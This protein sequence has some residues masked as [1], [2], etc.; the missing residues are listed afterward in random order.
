MLAF[1]AETRRAA[2]HRMAETP[3]DLL[4]IGGGITG[5]GIALDAASRGLSV[6]LVEKDDFASGTSGRSSRLVHGGIRYVPNGDL[7]LVH[8]ALRERST[9]RHLAPHLARPVPMYFP[10]KRFRDR[11]SWQLGLTVYDT[12]AWGQNIRRHR[13]APADEVARAIPGLG[14][15]APAVVYHECRTD[16]ARLTLEIARTAHG[17]GAL[18]ANHAEVTA[19][20]GDGRIAG[21]V[22]A[23]RMTGERLEVRAPL[24]VNAA[25]V[26]ADRIQS[27]GTEAPNH[28]RPSKGVHVVFRPGAVTTRVA[29]VVPSVTKDDRFVFGVPWEGR[30]YAGTTDTDY[31]GDLDD[32]AA[33]DADIDYV[34]QAMARAFPVTQADVV[35]SWAGLRPLLASGGRSASDLSRRHAIYES[36]PGLLTITGGKLTTYRAMAEDLVDRACRML[37][38]PAPCR[39]TSIRLGLSRDLEETF[40]AA[41]T[42]AGRLGL[43][44]GPARRLVERYGDDWIEAV[45]LIAA[46]RSLGE[47]VVDGFPVLRVELDL[48]RTREMALTDDDVFARRT[49]LSTMGASLLPASVPDVKG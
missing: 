37:D 38:E 14:Y 19:L 44:P 15:A 45:R 48:A 42:E 5:C 33:T 24:T 11:L 43:D 40:D 25:G 18:I 2:L 9:I 6:A 4:V 31:D 16:D 13:V 39:T 7:A 32:P 36:P 46:D 12:L 41:R 28:L 20:L 10:A 26:W 35:A 30:I 47:P 49:R 23:D 17:F 3:L 27:L 34:V 21:A 8:E 29:V 22:V 1:S